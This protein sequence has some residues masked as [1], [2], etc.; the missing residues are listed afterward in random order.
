MLYQYAGFILDSSIS[1]PSLEPLPPG[2]YEGNFYLRRW[3][4]PCHQFS[5][6]HDWQAEG[7][8]SDPVL[9]LSFRD[10]RFMLRA[11]GLAKV[12]IEQDRLY[13]CPDDDSEANQVSGA[14]AASIE[15]V[16]LDQALPRFLAHRGK[17]VLH[18]GAVCCEEICLGLVGAS[19]L[20]KSTLTASFDG[21][22]CA[23]LGDDGLALTSCAGGVHAVATYKSLRLLSDSLH[24]LFARS[25]PVTATQDYSNK[26]R[27][28]YQR[29]GRQYLHSASLGA[30]YF[31][32]EPK[33]DA[34]ADVVVRRLTSREACMAIVAAT[35]QLDVT[36]ARHV[37]TLL[38]QA[39]EV[40]NRVPAYEIAY[41][42]DF[43]LLP[44][45][46]AAILGRRHEWCSPNPVWADRLSDR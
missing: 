20:G 5:H 42:R 9:S 29:P 39:S 24:E 37:G 8:S 25:R 10:D 28:V 3:L 19:G 44:E 22:G 33:K 35:F 4:G 45:V 27:V 13:V 12:V 38:T 32:A 40:A 30:L 36:D 6:I 41:P 34:P 11:P 15:H 43:S 2:S 26:H 17:L 16:L 23:M 1:L 21:A 7:L 18:A 46:R 14:M 31:L